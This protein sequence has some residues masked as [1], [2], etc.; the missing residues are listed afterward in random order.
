MVSRG[1]GVQSIEI[2]LTRR[3]PG[4]CWGVR[5]ACGAPLI[6]AR[7]F[8]IDYAGDYV[9]EQELTTS[10]TYAFELTHF[11]RRD[12][13]TTLVV[14]ARRRGNAARYLNHPDEGE[15]ANCKAVPVFSSVDDMQSVRFYRIAI[16]ALE[17][18]TG[19]QE[20]LLQYPA[21]PTSA[22]GE[23]ADGAGDEDRKMGADG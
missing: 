8:I 21:D 1:P 4:P 18:I 12:A 22:S 15:V 14:D 3:Q 9:T 13:T 2:F 7:A 10:D 20:L 6:P 5:N 16:F 19:G 11:A 17:D 23:V